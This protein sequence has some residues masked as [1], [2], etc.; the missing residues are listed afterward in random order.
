M[1]SN[2]SYVQNC[3]NNDE[4]TFPRDK[5]LKVPSHCY[6]L[7]CNVVASCGRSEIACSWPGV[8]LRSHVLAIGLL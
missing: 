6:D 4:H 2:R 5:D 1:L 7:S 3:T 8:V